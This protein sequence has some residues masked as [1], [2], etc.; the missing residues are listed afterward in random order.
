MNSLN[1]DIIIEV[2]FLTAEE[3]GR[4]SPIEGG[5]Y[6]CPIIANGRGFDCRFVLEGTKRFEPG[7]TYRIQVKLLDAATALSELKEEAEISLWEGRN[8]A[9]GR[10][11]K[12]LD[13]Q[14][15]TL[16]KL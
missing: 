12:V 5:R 10:V 8:I 1:P 7:K 16:G 4:R 11:F 2:R 6:G 14:T 13:C 3:G 15:E 9:E